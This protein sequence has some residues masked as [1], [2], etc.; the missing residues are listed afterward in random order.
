MENKSQEEKIKQF[1]EKENWEFVPNKSGVFIYKSID[2]THSFNVDA[3]IE[4][5]I[6]FGS[7]LT[8]ERAREKVEE[9]MK[10]HAGMYLKKTTIDAVIEESKI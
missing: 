10:P 1:K 7:L 4:Q 5:A 3:L 6:Q 2:G 8:I 9:I